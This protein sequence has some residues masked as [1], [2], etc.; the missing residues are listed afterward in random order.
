MFKVYFLSAGAELAAYEEASL[1]LKL[2]RDRLR[3]LLLTLKVCLFISCINF[4]LF[5]IFVVFLLSSYAKEISNLDYTSG[6]TPKSVTNGGAQLRIFPGQPSS[7]ETLRR[8][9]AVGDTSSG[10]TGPNR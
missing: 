10:L 2:K 3:E 4:G 7:E 1:L 8:W 9:R 6:I 5:P